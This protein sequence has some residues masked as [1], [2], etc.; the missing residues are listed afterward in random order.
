MVLHGKCPF[1][2]ATLK[3]QPPPAPLPYRVLALSGASLWP[4]PGSLRLPSTSAVQPGDGQIA[5][6]RGGGGS[7]SP[8]S[9]PSLPRARG[10]SVA[11][12]SRWPRLLRAGKEPCM[13][14]L[15]ACLVSSHH[16]YIQHVCGGVSSVLQAAS[17]RPSIWLAL[18]CCLRRSSLRSHS[19]SADL[20]LAQASCA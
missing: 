3:F 15:P 2:I 12:L 11:L 4:I 9:R 16:T 6:C 13:G 1:D 7:S 8:S 17:L 18:W 14:G 19:P 10:I 20:L 5:T